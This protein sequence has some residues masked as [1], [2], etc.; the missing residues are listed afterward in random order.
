MGGQSNVDVRRGAIANWMVEKTFNSLLAVEG[1]SSLASASSVELDCMRAKLKALGV[2]EAEAH[3]ALSRADSNENKFLEYDEFSAA[4]HDEDTLQALVRKCC[5]C[6]T[7]SAGGGSSQLTL[8]GCTRNAMVQMFSMPLGNR[9][10][11]SQRL[12]SKP[13]TW[14]E[15]G[16]WVERIRDSLRSN[17]F[18]QQVTGLFVGIAA[19]YYAA[20]VAGIAERIVSKK[21]AME[22]L[23][24]ALA[25]LDASDDR[26]IANLTLVQEI[27]RWVFDDERSCL[28]FK[29]AWNANGAS[30]IATWTLGW[31]IMQ[32]EGD[33]DVR[34]RSVC[35]IQRSR[36][37]LVLGRSCASRASNLEGCERPGIRQ[38]VGTELVGLE[39]R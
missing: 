22:A 15:R 11:S 3:A 9:L 33:V 26:N 4:I 34:E 2:Q 1:S 30:Y 10:P 21:E 36:E 18:P 12:F 23:A 35:N 14:E 19:M 25:K 7:I 5:F 37:E 20:K 31:Y 27:I 32:F 6:G 38:S 24:D 16:E 8:T 39:R 29:R 17:H 28:L 13:V